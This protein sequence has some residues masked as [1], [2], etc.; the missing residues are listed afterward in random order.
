MSKCD[1]TRLAG[2][3]RREVCGYGGMWA[4]TEL[5]NSSAAWAEALVEDVLSYTVAKGRARAAGEPQPVQSHQFY[6]ALISQFGRQLA[7]DLRGP[8]CRLREA[9]C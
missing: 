8:R 6:S 5:D 7:M 2:L 9:G 1:S 3:I 4:F